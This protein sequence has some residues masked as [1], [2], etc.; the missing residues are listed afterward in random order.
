MSVFT[1]EALSSTQELVSAP[2]YH[3]LSS[4]PIP[5]DEPRVITSYFESIPSLCN[6]EGTGAGG[7]AIRREIRELDPSFD[8]LAPI[9]K[10]PRVVLREEE[11]GSILFSPTSGPIFLNRPATDLL[12]HVQKEAANGLTS[13]SYERLVNLLHDELLLKPT[14]LVSYQQQ[15]S[16]ALNYPISATLELTYSCHHAC[17]HC[18][19][20]S[21]PKF[22]RTDE[23]PLDYWKE[24]IRAMAE[25]GLCDIYFSGGEI[26]RYEGWGELLNVCDDLGLTYLIVSDLAG[27]TEDDFKTLSRTRNLRAVM[28]SLDGHDPE[29]H[30]HLRGRGAFEKTV[31]GIKRLVS[32]GVPAGVYHMVHARNLSSVPDFIAFANSLGISNIITGVACPIGRGASAL[33]NETLDDLQCMDLTRYYL[34]AISDGRVE[35]SHSAWRKLSNEYAETGFHDNVFAIWRDFAHA[36]THRIHLSPSGDI[37]LCP[38]LQGTDFDIFGNVNTTSIETA[39]ASTRMKTIRSKAEMKHLIVGASYR[40]FASNLLITPT[41]PGID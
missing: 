23:L 31:A 41:R 1:A 32:A 9:S 18:M 24:L 2:S 22:A 35:P 8:P 36:G 27:H 34:E 4:E 21:S 39:W 13:S 19:Y 11:F 40:E 7:M 15:L 14:H 17:K 5:Q 30:D 29:T 6:G 3:A 10:L 37:R 16:D 38:K 12:L 33:H 26:A 28:V 20:S 25:R